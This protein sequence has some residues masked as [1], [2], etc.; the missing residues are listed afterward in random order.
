MDDGLE[1]VGTDWRWHNNQQAQFLEAQRGLRS[2]GHTGVCLTAQRVYLSACSKLVSS[3]PCRRMPHMQTPRRP[4]ASRTHARTHAHARRVLCTCLLYA[5]VKVAEAGMGHNLI[6]KTDET[7]WGWGRN[8]LG[9]LGDGTKT[10]R[11]SAV[12]LNGLSGQCWPQYTPLI[13]VPW[14]LSL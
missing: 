4:Y 6:V 7:V 3:G 12:K 1:P 8:E 14:Q 2:V 10:H 11:L 5:D 13:M 9:A